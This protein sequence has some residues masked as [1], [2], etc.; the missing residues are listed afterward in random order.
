MPIM[1]YKL[2]TLYAVIGENCRTNSQSGF[3]PK[4]Q[5][6][7]KEVLEIISNTIFIICHGNAEY[8]SMA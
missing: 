7:S 3:V 1:W 4:R 2:L 5:L 6:H 8:T